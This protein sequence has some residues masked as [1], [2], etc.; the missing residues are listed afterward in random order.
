MIVRILSE[1]Q[2]ELAAEALD[3]LKHLDE[4]LFASIAASD[5]QRYEQSFHAALSL[6]R[7]KGRRVPDDRLVESDL[8]LPTSDTTL[9]EARRLFTEQ[10]R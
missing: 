8:I 6:V 5:E 9:E 3:R 10:T 2:F 1:G 4:D 7:E